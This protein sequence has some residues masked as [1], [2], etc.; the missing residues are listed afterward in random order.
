[1]NV[2]LLDSLST[3]S[4]SENPIPGS[5]QFQYDLMGTFIISTSKSNRRCRGNNADEGILVVHSSVLC[6]PI[7]WYNVG[8]YVHS[9]DRNWES[10]VFRQLLCKVFKNLTAPEFYISLNLNNNKIVAGLI[11]QG[12]VIGTLLGMVL[13]VRF[14]PD[15]QQVAVCAGNQIY[16]LNA[17]VRY[18][19]L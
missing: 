14:S 13:H 18:H 17:K 10:S 3:L 9:L 6:F 8:C 2:A 4:C 7:A 19:P 12:I 5:V 16:M 15:D 11:P 1:M